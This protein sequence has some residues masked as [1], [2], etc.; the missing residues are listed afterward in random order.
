[1]RTMPA[2]MLPTSP[3]APH[4]A[5]A[6]VR[7]AGHD[8]TE[9][10]E[11]ELNKDLCPKSEEEQAFISSAIQKSEFLEGCLSTA[12][13]P[14]CTH[15]CTHPSHTAQRRWHP[16]ENPPVSSDCRQLSAPPCRRACLTRF[17]I[18]T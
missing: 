15:P 16:T 12:H 9:M 18:D 17:A 11:E 4:G 5:A 10:T 7:R 14:H 1:V 6:N 13:G 8:M 3:Y 2:R